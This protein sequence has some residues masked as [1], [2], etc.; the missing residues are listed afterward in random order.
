MIWQQEG[1]PMLE[2]VSQRTADDST[3]IIAEQARKVR[4]LYPELF[5]HLA[6]RERDLRKLRSRIPNPADPESWVPFNVYSDVITRVWHL[7]AGI[8]DLASGRSR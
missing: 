3:E 6:D 4:A 8:D 7:P 1:N 2:P 5:A